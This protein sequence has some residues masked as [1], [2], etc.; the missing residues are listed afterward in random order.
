V[1]GTH[2]PVLAQE[3]I[4]WLA[5]RADGFYLDTTYGRGGHSSLIL[6]RLG[7]E[8][9]LVAC[10]RDPEARVDACARFGD[11]SRFRFMGMAFSHL[12]QWVIEQGLAGRIAGVLADLGV[13]SPQLEDPARGFSFSHEGSLDMRMNPEQGRSA[14]EWINRAAAQEIADVLYYYGDE[15]YSRRI[16]RAIVTRREE[17]PLVTTRALAETIARAIPR[18]ERRIHPATRSLQAIRIYINDELG[19][20]RRL[21]EAVPGL[22]MPGGRLVVIAFHS[23]ED[24]IV[25]RFMRL[26]AHSEPP[27]LRIVTRMIQPADTETMTNPR[28]R[29]ARLRVAE[30]PA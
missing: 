3:A 15:R 27:K 1:T 12:P 18:R 14:A 21:L 2:I 8:G 19:E 17:H 20:L 9:R 23:I 22:L 7:P 26:A 28:A 13:S 10:D 6:E 5:I 4:E 11:D 24:R 16:A 30:A 29:S 25:K